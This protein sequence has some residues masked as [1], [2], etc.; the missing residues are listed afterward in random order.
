MSEGFLPTG[1]YYATEVVSA[2]GIEWAG[3]ALAAGGLSGWVEDV[4]HSREYLPAQFWS[5]ADGRA[6]LEAGALVDDH[7]RRYAIVLVS[8]LPDYPL[9]GLIEAS[10]KT[11]ISAPAAANDA[12]PDGW[13]FDRDT[14]LAVWVRRARP[15]AEERLKSRGQS[16]SEPKIA[17]EL[18]TMAAS[19]GRSVKVDTVLRY[20][21]R[22][23]ETGQ[24]A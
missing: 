3:R 8:N 14:L 12:A 22:D 7:G 16:L 4:D 19:A 11:A 21:R 5:T 6:A 18:R 1:H 15:Y 20:M 23:R 24:S 2:G 10:R 17:E 13:R 9:S